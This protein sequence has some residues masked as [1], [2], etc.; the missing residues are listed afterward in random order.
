MSGSACGLGKASPPGVRECSVGHV[1]KS[2]MITWPWRAG[3]KRRF[4]FLMFLPFFQ[5]TDEEHFYLKTD[6][7][8]WL[9]VGVESVTFFGLSRKWHHG[10]SEMCA[11]VTG[12]RTA[13]HAEF[14]HYQGSYPASRYQWVDY[15]E[16]LTCISYLGKQNVAPWSLSSGF[17]LGALTRASSSSCRT[18]AWFSDHSAC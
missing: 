5:V 17:Y 14:G 13:V 16:A 9:K 6:T 3:T 10:Q 12:K 11:R 7:L 18:D 4:W 2:S 8:F 1:T 15:G